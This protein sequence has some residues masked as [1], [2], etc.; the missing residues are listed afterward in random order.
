M[1]DSSA[2]YVAELKLGCWRVVVPRRG[3]LT[4][5]VLQEV[6]RCKTDA[7]TWLRSPRGLAVTQAAQPISRIARAFESAL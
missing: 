2:A 1:S 7:L 6:F 4:P 3:K 5:L